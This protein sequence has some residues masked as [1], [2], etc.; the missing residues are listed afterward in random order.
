MPSEFAEKVINL[1]TPNVGSAVAK[2]IVTEACKNMNAD[3]ETI[4]ENNLTPFLA[5]IEKKLILRAGPVIVNKTLD[6]IKEFGEKKTITSNKAVPETK[7]DVEIDKEINTFLEKNILPTEND[8]TDYAKYLAM[9]YGGDARTVEKNLIDKV[10]SHV[11][12]TISRKKIMNEIRLFL[13]NF[14]GAN[15][16]DIDDFITYSRM[17]KLN[18]NDDE[19]RLQIESERL[20]RKFGN[21]HKDEAP[22]IDKFIDI[23]KVSKDKS[24]V[25]NAMK[26]QGLTYLI[27]DESGDPDKSLTDFMELIVPS[28]KDMKDALQNMGLDH[29]IK[30]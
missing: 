1:L 17:L 7:L 18:F 12:D 3:V 21:F 4:D 22:E 23:L 8:V 15:K 19:M 6:K 27:K 26:K 25:G 24:A 5:Q 10:R 28:E 30:K 9:K 16:T 13:N 29:L 20:A 14:P 11:K 2:S